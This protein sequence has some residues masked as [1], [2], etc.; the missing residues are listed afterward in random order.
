MFLI[1]VSQSLAAVNRS[2][3]IEIDR[4]KLELSKAKKQIVELENTI[5]KLFN[6]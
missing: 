6:L 4:L 3:Q 1:D 5:K 2:Q